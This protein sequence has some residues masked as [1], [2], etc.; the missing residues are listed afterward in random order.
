MEYGV[1]VRRNEDMWMN[2]VKVISSWKE[3]P[4]PLKM[5]GICSTS[6]NGATKRF[7]CDVQQCS[8]MAVGRIC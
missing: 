6:E 2:V 8:G 4:V 5:A 7:E 1:W 3:G